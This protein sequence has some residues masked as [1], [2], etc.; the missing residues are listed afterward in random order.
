MRKKYYYL[1][2]FWLIISTFTILFS[3]GMNQSIILPNET[4]NYKIEPY[5]TF[6]NVN[7]I[8]N[9]ITEPIIIMDD[10][11]FDFY[12]FS[13]NGTI[14]N[15]YLIQYITIETNLEFGIFITNVSKNFIIQNC[16]ITSQISAISLSNIT[17]DTIEINNNVCHGREWYGIYVYSTDNVNI[18]NNKCGGSASG[19]VV[20]FSDNG[21]IGDN[22]CYENDFGI[23]LYETMNFQ[24][25]KN[26]CY[27]NSNSGIHILYSSIIDANNNTLVNNVWGLSFLSS[28]ASSISN[29]LC[30]KSYY[31]IYAFYSNTIV[32]HNNVCLRSHYGIK[33]EHSRTM[34][35]K[36]NNCSF[37]FTGLYITDDSYSMITENICSYNIQTGI[38]VLLST[39]NYV[40]SNSVF[41]NSYGID[42]FRSISSVSINLC[43][44]NDIGIR[45]WIANSIILSNNTCNN[46]IN[47]IIIRE[48]DFSTISYNV[49]T[50][51]ID[52]GIYIYEVSTWNKIHHNYFICNNRDGTE[53]GYSQAYDEGYNNRWYESATDE[54]NYW[55]D[56]EGIGEYQIDGKDN[57]TDPYPFVYDYE[58]VTITETTGENTEGSSITIL[59]TLFAFLGLSSIS[60]NLRKRLRK[61]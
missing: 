18:S 58:C 40:M 38:D 28:S 47:G 54:G 41:N 5:Q 20:Y 45:L 56:H 46:N 26:Y 23:A 1:I 17:S 43:Y 55:N 12:G 19:I 27:N 24:I 22:E 11:D 4:L 50:R 37:G 7:R 48:T 57:N 60:T 15:P 29:N 35:V 8:K 39:S 14:Q 33:L 52:Y 61:L 34:T 21:Y 53:H 13:G 59:I 31:G 49:L 30:N 6:G 16:V 42:I 2:N 3:T 32:I 44:N 25:Y 51:N 10:V 36:E 9:S